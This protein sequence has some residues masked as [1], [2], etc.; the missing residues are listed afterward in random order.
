M[1]Q[2]HPWLQAFKIPETQ[3][4]EWQAHANSGDNF[5]FWCLLEGKIPADK[6]LSWAC[7][8]YGLAVVNSKFFKSKANDTLWK[9]IH[10]VANWSRE[11]LPLCEWDGVVFIACVEPKNEIQWSFPVR[12][13]L[14]S[15]QDLETYWQAL[16][17]AAPTAVPVPAPAAAKPEAEIEK[18]ATPVVPAA[19][20][21]TPAPT[22][23]A[24]VAATKPEAPN[25]PDLPELPENTASGVEE[26][27]PSDMPEGLNLNL[28]STSDGASTDDPLA[29]LEAAVAKSTD[30]SAAAAPEGIAI[31][32]DLPAVDEALPSP[33]ASASAETPTA[34]A[35]PEGLAPDVAA[36]AAVDSYLS[37]IP[38]HN[39]HTT[40]AA[41]KDFS[42]DPS[43]TRISV[44]EGDG[45]VQAYLNELRVDFQGAMV[46]TFAD[47]AFAPYAWDPSWKP[48]GE[49]KG[50]KDLNGPSAFR[51]AFRTKQPYLGHIV[52]TPVNREFFTQWG[53]AELPK[54]I[55]IQPL[56]HNEKIM[57]VLVCRCPG[58]DTHKNS[59]ILLSGQTHGQKLSELLK[60]AAAQAA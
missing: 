12:Y 55:L 17:P 23:Q 33:E 32:L 13:V 57:G 59:Q 11:M 9:Q 34:E 30:P 28:G 51:I 58:A 22:P 37:K 10:S 31:K 44:P 2:Q 41:L 19:T 3:A 52:D 6:Y 29:S 8:H 35:A 53:E 47:G 16:H 14:A 21:A 42:S 5:T 27:A 20:P 40:E 60:P 1:T 48:V 39:E 54:R 25:L 24:E 49:P 7:E 15:A 46:L 36:A 4:H 43:I 38:H 26:A 45:S 50:P 18:P 56:L